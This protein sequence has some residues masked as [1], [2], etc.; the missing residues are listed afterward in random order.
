MWGWGGSK[1][2]TEV[3]R[4]GASAPREPDVFDVDIAEPDISDADLNDPA[5]LAELHNLSRSV[6]AGQP[7]QKS[8]S[9]KKVARKPVQVEA[10]IDVEALV[11]G[12]PAGDD[13]VDVQLD[14]SD[15]NDPELL[16]ALGALGG[17]NESGSDESD[18][19]RRR[20]E[21]GPR[22]VTITKTVT[23]ISS[24]PEGS[25]PK[26]VEMPVPK[27]EQPN[28]QD[29]SLPLDFKLR[30]TDP[31]VLVKYVQLEK[32]KALN[33]KRAGDREGA[34]DALRASKTLEERLEQ[35]NQAIEA[36]QSPPPHVSLT[37]FDEISPPPRQ[38]SITEKTVTV[39]LA[40]P[41]TAPEEELDLQT[42]S[43]ADDDGESKQAVVGGLSVEDL[44]RR[45]LEYKQYALQAKKANDLPRAREFLTIAKLLQEPIDSLSLGGMLPDGY[46]LP[47]HPSEMPISES[48]APAPPSGAAPA[49]QQPSPAKQT[50]V[51]PAPGKRAG[52]TPKSGRKDGTP[53]GVVV[54]ESVDLRDVESALSSSPPSPGP[55]PTGDLFSHLEATLE[56]QIATCTTVAAHYYK[57][58]KKAEALTF[59]KM[60]KTLQADLDTLRL[61]KST[62]NPRPPAFKYTT[63]R[64]EIEQAI[65]EVAPD[66]MEIQVVRAWDLGTREV[67]GE[68]VES[69]VAFDV[70]WPPDDAEGAGASGEGK[71]ETAVVKR[72]ASPEYEFS[73][74]V[75]IARNRTF[76]RYLERRKAT[77][78]VFHYQRG[79]LL[80][81]KKV[82]LGRIQIKMEPLLTKCDIHEVAELADPNNPRRL[83]GG[84][85]EVRIRLRSPLNKPDVVVKEERWLS[86]DFS[87][88]NQ[89][90]GSPPTGEATA[91]GGLK[92]P[93][94]TTEQTR[95]RSPSPSSIKS[96]SPV[97]PQD[98]ESGPS[99]G[100][101]TP[102]R[103]ASPQ[104][105]SSGSSATPTPKR[106]PSPQ[107]RAAESGADA[108]EELEMQFMSAD[109]I[110]S[111]LVLEKEHEQI[112]Q[113]ITA[114]QASRKPVPDD[115]SD[116]KTAYEIR[117]S[118]LVTMVQT[119][120]LSV[121][122]YVKQLQNG[123][124]QN[125]QIALTFK[126]GG[127]IELAKQALTRVKLM[128]SEMEE[129]SGEGA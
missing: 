96:T 48:P 91:P 125:K 97:S 69:Y 15:L 103:Q 127:R 67:K 19:D 123:I 74:R 80:I 81:G 102:K 100:V 45:Q 93:T 99:S 76:Q 111:N 32:I 84:K 42:L 54:R 63:L 86:V 33:K 122:D 43:L 46:K 94:V 85:L 72:S 11:S 92:V 110:I 34:M 4:G 8:A 30:S 120:R 107:P 18:V 95:S 82:S 73:K 52:V 108:L 40:P 98:G 87:G 106:Q 28:V 112:V 36:K 119:G 53:L 23:T 117:M 116:R 37:K 66:E 20:S 24:P 1:K 21:D 65:P 57:Q 118:L 38:A 56:S 71:G 6:A 79:F 70:G 60:K 114:L 124:A 109:S 77:F 126:K 59:H 2:K 55:A 16:A 51:K 47:V 41:E 90:E 27:A 12:I 7:T 129:L 75:K 121:E 115:L 78:E 35:V 9:P 105:A 25:A 29:E 10:E 113:K 58:T 3:S 14:E 26:A 39:T 64:Y 88:G 104:P 83:T 128:T 44:T 61:L 22:P 68:E 50:P 101:P 62:P 89:V 49:S 31:N 13:D 5:L 17:G